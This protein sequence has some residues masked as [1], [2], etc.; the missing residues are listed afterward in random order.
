MADH[1][2]VKVSERSPVATHVCGRSE[3]GQNLVRMQVIL[4]KFVREAITRAEFGL[5]A[6]N[7]V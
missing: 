7:I 4:S 6:C 5:T 1:F 3:Q 2:R